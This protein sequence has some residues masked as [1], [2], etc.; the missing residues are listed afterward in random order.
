M[1]LHISSIEHA[2]EI[3]YLILHETL[4]L[5]YRLLRK[6]LIEYILAFFGF[7]VRDEAEGRAILAEAVIETVFL[8][9]PVLIV[10]DVKVRLGIREM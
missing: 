8:I 5:P 1:E 7:L 9:P 4:C 6:H 2:Y 3:R 10:V